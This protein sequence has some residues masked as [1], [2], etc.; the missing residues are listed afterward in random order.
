[1]R[2]RIE[3]GEYEQPRIGLAVAER[4]RRGEQHADESAGEADAPRAGE[5]AFQLVRMRG[6]ALHRD[7]A[8]AHARERIEPGEQG[9]IERE[10]TEALDVELA[11]GQPQ[12]RDGATRAPKTPEHL[13]RGALEHGARRT[14]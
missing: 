7:L 13:Q 4:D 11:R 8:R 9:Q 10:A 6:G 5:H 12:D 2:E 14:D 1:V 3:R